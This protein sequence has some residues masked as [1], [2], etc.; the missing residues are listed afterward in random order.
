[1]EF[2]CTQSLKYALSCLLLFVVAFSFIEKRDR[3]N[4]II[5]LTNAKTKKLAL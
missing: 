3:E 4:Y 1:M 2:F 5:G